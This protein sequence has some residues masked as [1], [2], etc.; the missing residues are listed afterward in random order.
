MIVRIFKIIE[1]IDEGKPLDEVSGAWLKQ[2]FLRFMKGN[3]PLHLALNL[4]GIRYQYLLKVRN[5]YL[6]KALCLIDENL[7]DFKRAC[8]LLDMLYAYKS[9]QW[10]YIRGNLYPP[11]NYS[12]IDKCFF[13]ILKSD[14]GIPGNKQIRNIWKST[15]L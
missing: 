4:R 2:G 9:D 13:Y 12:Q 11:D 8:E 7:N 3:E 10:E 5:E 6:Y 15:K 1:A 14:V